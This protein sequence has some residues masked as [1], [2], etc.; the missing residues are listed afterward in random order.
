MSTLRRTLLLEEE[1]RIHV[2]TEVGQIREALNRLRE[3]RTRRAFGND[4]L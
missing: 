1:L 4:T 2:T 3:L